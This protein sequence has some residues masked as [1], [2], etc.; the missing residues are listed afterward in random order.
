M[1]VKLD[2]KQIE[3]T[4]YIWSDGMP[5]WVPIET[6]EDFFPKA[7][8]AIT[9]KGS[10]P[11]VKNTDEQVKTNSV[12]VS[13]HENEKDLKKET[14]TDLNSAHT[15]NE[16]PNEKVSYVEADDGDH[17]LV[18]AKEPTVKIEISKKLL[19]QSTNVKDEKEVTK[20]ISTNS[21]SVVKFDMQESIW[22]LYSKNIYSGPY[23]AQKI[24]EMLSRKEIHETD[25][26]WR[27]GID[28]SIMISSVKEIMNSLEE[29]L[30]AN[31]KKIEKQIESSEQPPL[32]SPEIETSETPKFIGAEEPEFA[33][34]SEIISKKNRFK[35]PLI[36]IS[37]IIIVF[38]LI[39]SGLFL[40]ENSFFFSL[41]L[42]TAFVKIASIDG[43]SS[44][45]LVS[46]RLLARKDP[47]QSPLVNVFQYMGEEV[48]P[49][50]I[51]ATN[52]PD[53][54]MF[55][56]E[57]TGVPGTL[58]NSISYHNIQKAESKNFLIN[59]PRFDASDGRALPKGEY[60]IK[61]MLSKAQPQ[62]IQVLL[63]GNTAVFQMKVFIGGKRDDNY[64][65][66]L[67][68]YLAGVD[69]QYQNELTESKQLL[70][71]FDSLYQ[72]TNKSY[73]LIIK[74]KKKERNLKWESFLAK[75]QTFISVIE[76][77][78][79]K[80]SPDI[81]KMMMNAELFSNLTE[82]ISELKLYRASLGASIA[83]KPEDHI[84]AISH[85]R[86]IV[87]FQQSIAKL[88]QD[89]KAKIDSIEMN[90][91]LP[92][93][94]GTNAPQVVPANEQ[95]EMNSQPDPSKANNANEN[96]EPKESPQKELPKDTVK[97]TNVIGESEGN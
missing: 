36:A 83:E 63:G 23:T 65:K 44:N 85:G 37:S 30:S 77:S 69:K 64:R 22:V 21:S 7:K 6:V 87:E 75:S 28:R 32:V 15:T 18:H 9:E 79:N 34:E 35:K 40:T 26:I 67:G 59:I 31:S 33:H 88:L 20:K 80:Y 93:I 45:D 76:D 46:M 2:K 38:A 4:T 50:F 91:P 81:L 71:N 90:P 1:K 62:D 89:Y 86:T 96:T 12:E 5:D 55:D 11:P 53:G 72:E 52:M 61:A 82:I 42:P 56:I 48:S 74:L 43:I 78:C 3:L 92:Q 84:K 24:L 49:K 54:T 13:K 19:N 58:I 66:K 17:L 14:P 10:E 60:T 47:S 16:N 39:T 57:L 29:L 51:A 41:P 27:E 73:D 68:E 94:P 97:E 25:K 8:S 95:T 70:A